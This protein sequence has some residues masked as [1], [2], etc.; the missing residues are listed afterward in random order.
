[1]HLPPLT[2][3][4]CCGGMP[5][6]WCCGAAPR[7][8]AS[9]MVNPLRR[10]LRRMKTDGRRYY[11]R[12][13]QLRRIQ[14]AQ[15]PAFMEALR[16]KCIRCL[17][18]GHRAADCREP[19]RCISCRRFGHKSQGLQPSSASLCSAP[20]CS[21]CAAPTGPQRVPTPT[22]PHHAGP[23]GPRDPPRGH[24]RS[25]GCDQRD[26]RRSCA[27]IFLRRGARSTQRPPDG[28]AAGACRDDGAAGLRCRAPQ[29]RWPEAAPRCCQ[30]KSQRRGCG[31]LRPRRGAARGHRWSRSQRR[32]LE[33]RSGRR[34]QVGSQAAGGVG[35]AEVIAVVALA[36]ALE[37][38]R[39][40]ASRIRA[41]R[42]ASALG[43]SS[44]G[45]AQRSSVASCPAGASP[46]AGVSPS[47]AHV[48][49]S[50]SNR[51]RREREKDEREEQGHQRRG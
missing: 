45:P 25:G 4:R 7:S 44:L 8:P 19:V 30:T 49:P 26:G 35:A 12:S 38:G 32:E 42:R 20:A 1:M 6:R 40:A 48:E 3:G 28:A 14:L 37:E 39:P 34:M 2:S 47:G 27:P 46:P 21:R 16:G 17:A 24:Q 13:V 36:A 29:A 41:R 11:R 15:R 9:E 43:P 51:R 23:W 33:R 5:R 18:V 22:V 31:A 50:P 10:D